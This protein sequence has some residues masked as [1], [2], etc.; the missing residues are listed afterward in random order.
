MART[1]RP[2]RR[3][4]PLRR[5]PLP[6]PLS[7]A[8]DRR[9]TRPRR[10]TT[11]R[12]MV[13]TAPTRMPASRSTFK[14]VPRSGA[15]PTEPTSDHAP[16]ADGPPC[17]SQQA[18]TEDN[19]NKEISAPPESPRRAPAQ[20][21]LPHPPR[22]D[23][24]LLDRL[25]PH[26]PGGLAGPQLRPHPGPPGQGR[27]R[28]SSSATPPPPEPRETAEQIHRG[29]L[30]GLAAVRA[31]TIDDR[32][33]G[34]VANEFRNFQFVA[35]DGLKDVTAAFRHYQLATRG[36]SSAL[37]SRDRPAVGGR[38]GP[39]LADPAGRRRPDPALAHHPDA[40]LRTAGP[41]VSAASGPGST[42]CP[43]S[44]PGPASPSPPTRAASGPSPCQRPRLRPGRALQHRARAGEAPRPIRRAHGQR[45]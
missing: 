23:P 18:L 16:V 3:Q 4:R 6:R 1:G 15:R 7:P 8:P 45:P 17:P 20:R 34:T 38:D 31:R 26:S 12:P 14:P 11:H 10:P 5:P 37:P 33:A 29:L 32:R 27:A 35:P 13:A 41:D 30:D 19:R 2:A 24:G 9:Q 22:R 44:S 25:R 28:P 43:P 36:T 42:A 40:P 21:R 39:L